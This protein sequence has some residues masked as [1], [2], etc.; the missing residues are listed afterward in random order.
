[1]NKTIAKGNVTKR[2][3]HEG[4]NQKKIFKRQH[5]RERN[6]K[7][8]DVQHKNSYTNNIILKDRHNEDN[9]DRC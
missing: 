7:H 9:D 1:M 2:K 4:Q 8:Y 5:K 3:Y 6:K